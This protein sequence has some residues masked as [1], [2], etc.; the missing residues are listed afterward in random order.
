M[1]RGFYSGIFRYMNHKST[2]YVLLFLIYESTT[3][4]HKL[5]ALALLRFTEHN[6]A[7]GFRELTHKKASFHVGRVFCGCFV[8]FLQKAISI[9]VELRVML[10]SL[11]AGPEAMNVNSC[12]FILQ[13]SL[14][15]FVPLWQEEIA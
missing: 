12:F 3:V 4:K 10:T 13:G 7:V 14:R 1:K 9:Q 11:G 5:R 8:L 6:M 15:H 2:A